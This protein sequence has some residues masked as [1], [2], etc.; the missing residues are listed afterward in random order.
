MICGLGLLV[1]GDPHLTV[2]MQVAPT[3]YNKTKHELKES[4]EVE[5]TYKMLIQCQ[6]L[7]I[8]I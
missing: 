8:K 3:R 5:Y 7:K 4:K 2:I 1:Q 6:F